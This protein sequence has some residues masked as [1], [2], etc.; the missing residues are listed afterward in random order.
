MAKP[1][2]LHLTKY[3]TNHNHREFKGHRFW[4]ACL[5]CRT[6]LPVFYGVCR[7]IVHRSQLSGVCCQTFLRTVMPDKIQQSSAPASGSGT[8]G[9]Y[10]NPRARALSESCKSVWGSVVRAGM[11]C[12]S[13]A[14]RAAPDMAQHLRRVSCVHEAGGAFDVA[15]QRTCGRSRGERLRLLAAEEIGCARASGVDLPK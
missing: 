12:T 11:S 13:S 9:I 10:G 8:S 14:G 5:L 4:P 2:S 1:R 15:W 3:S 7:P 6:Q